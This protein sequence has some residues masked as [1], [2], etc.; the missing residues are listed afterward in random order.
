MADT[1]VMGN[2]ISIFSTKGGVG[3]TLLAVNLAIALAQ[4]GKKVAL[5]DLDLQAIQDMARMIDATPQYSVFDIVSILEKV[6]QA[7]NIKNYMTFVSAYGI[8]FLPAITRPK[9]SPHI[10]GDR[11][12]KVITMLAPFYDFI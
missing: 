10:T 11:I 2:V 12:G 3:K 9:Q 1:P 7:G 5:I 6:E 8:D 4:E